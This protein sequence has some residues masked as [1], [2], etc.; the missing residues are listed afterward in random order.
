MGTH[1][2]TIEQVKN[3]VKGSKSWRQTAFTLGLNGDAGGNTK[4]LKKLAEKNGI[5]FSHFLGKRINL[6]RKTWNHIPLEDWLKKGVI[7]KSTYLKKKLISAGIIDNICVECELHDNWN[8][9][10]IE[11]ELDHIDGDKSNNLL[12][13]LRLLCP[14]C[15]SQT[16]TF[17]GRK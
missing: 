1:K 12:D 14:N 2:Y 5:D 13:N 4:T 8:G 9:L 17:R 11:L 15:H 6:G 10:P 3:A 7:V 16:P